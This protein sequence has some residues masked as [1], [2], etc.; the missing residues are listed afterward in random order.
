MLVDLCINK[1]L[2]GCSSV[3]V[4]ISFSLKKIII[5]R[6]LPVISPKKKK[7]RCRKCSFFYKGF[8]VP[9]SKRTYHVKIQVFLCMSIFSDISLEVT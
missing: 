7:T 5:H 6:T 3:S 4:D 9:N 8:E 2:K 1:L